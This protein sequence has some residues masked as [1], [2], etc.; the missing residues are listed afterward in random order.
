MG[1]GVSTNASVAN[2]VVATVATHGSLSSSR[3]GT[4]GELARERRRHRREE[5][6]NHL[7]QLQRLREELCGKR[8]ALESR[9][10]LLQRRQDDRGD[11]TDVKR[12]LQ[13]T[14]QEIRRVERATE[15]VEAELA[16]FF[17]GVGALTAP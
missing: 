17:G 4:Y 12:S 6:E 13:D 10:Q 8:A 2:D 9:A 1:N 3:G 5:L 15:E 16:G 11:L 14:E 7:K